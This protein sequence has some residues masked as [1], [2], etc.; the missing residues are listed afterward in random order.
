MDM[1]FRILQR[2]PSDTLVIV[3][4]DPYSLQ[5]EKRWPWPRDRYATTLS[6]LQDAGASLIAFD[7]DFSSLSDKAGDAAFASHLSARPGEVVLPVFSQW[8]SHA[9]NERTV[10]QSPPHE[11]FLKDIVIASVN[12][13]A[14]DS[15][16]VRRGWFGF[17]KGVDYRATLAAT[18]AGAP[19]MRNEGFYIDYGI[20][21]SKIQR[22][23]FNDVLKGDFPKELVAGK[24][25]IIGA[26][27][28]ELGD[29]FAVPVSGI[30][31]GVVLHALSYES[32]VQNRTLMRPHVSLSLALA[33][34]VILC[35][36]R[37]G[38]DRRWRAATKL[39]IGVLAASISVPLAIQAL[40]PISLDLAAVIAAQFLCLI[41]VWFRELHTRAQHLIRHR[42]ATARFQALTSLVVSNNSDGVIVAAANGAVELC[43]DRARA[44]LGIVG[45]LTPHSSIANLAPGF[46]LF[47]PNDE[48]GAEGSN[49]ATDDSTQHFEYCVG[50]RADRVLEIV[51]AHAHYGDI[52]AAEAASSEA[53]HV[54]VYS[55]RDI[56]ARK[57]TE[58]AEKAAKEAA[59]A[60][61]HLKSQL[62]SN[63][64]HELRTP[65]NGVIGFA[66]LL[67]K[68][69]FGPLGVSEYKE[70]SQSIYV[71]G[72]R[73]LSVV[74][75]MLNIAK[76]DTHD[77][78]LQKEFTPLSDIVGQCITNCKE[79]FSD[80]EKS[81]SVEIPEEFPQLEIDFNV[82]TEMLAH[83]LSNAVKFTGKD[84]H[85]TIRAM[86][87]Q[88][89][90]IVE[91]EDNGCGVNSDFLPKLTEAFYQV[92]G[93]LSRKH[94]GVGLG[95]YLVS[96]FAALHNGSLEFDS[97]P[98]AGFTAR[99]RFKNIAEHKSRR[100]A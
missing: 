43:N 81:I 63:I 10:V 76:L 73:L 100:A 36:C 66:D 8:S 16:I 26:T 88:G 77:F 2:A 6:N 50:G 38:R 39:H 49:S 87:R 28:L 55:L 97:E 64:S 80:G 60:A 78:K 27:A 35:L 31:P 9:G 99:L 30:I 96:K 4:I 19:A 91:V 1:R 52:P 44:L 98:D 3:E 22:L 54:Y 42:L 85:I 51:A 7:V 90:L 41:Y 84:A 47:S 56:T 13:M 61:S 40:A 5:K 93:A 25:I 67:Q 65:L 79:Q 20:D 89:N 11:Y 12:L 24:N 59:I 69:S 33:L 37:T 29:E 15:G 62:I 14:E 34:F 72:K 21:S 95:L 82:F 68:E 32:L 53:S 70:F 46:P 48:L 75:D 57:Q 74:N 23:S 17:G 83:L 18:L 71:S 86:L 45:E 94:E 92:D 58:A